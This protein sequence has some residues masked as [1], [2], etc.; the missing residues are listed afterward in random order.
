MLSRVGVP[1]LEDLVD[2]TIPPDIRLER[3]LQ[4]DEARGEHELLADLAREGQQA[5]DF[6]SYL[7]TGYHDC[8]VPPVIQR[9]VLEDPSWY[10]QYTPYQAEISQGRLEA[11]LT[12]Q[13]MVADLT[14]LP[15]AGASLLDEATAAAEAVS[16]CWAITRRGA[17]GGTLL[18]LRALPPPDHRRGQDPGRGRGD[19]DHRGG[20][21]RRPTSR[22]PS[23]SWSSTP[24]PE[25]GWRTWRISPGACTTPGDSWWWPAICSP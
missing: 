2:Q 7:G 14:G 17:P 8:I 22:A 23:G 15:L 5:P 3:A 25:V 11:L 4:L 16:M 10:T 1:S 21:T 24:A 20:T 12:F 6:R 19:R 13:T 9:N 18:R